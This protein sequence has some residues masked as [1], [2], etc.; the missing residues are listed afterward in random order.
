MPVAARVNHEDDETDIGV[1]ENLLEE[2]LDSTIHFD[3]CPDGHTLTPPGPADPYTERRLRVVAAD[4]R[5]TVTSRGSDLTGDP[6]KTLTARLKSLRDHGLRLLEAPTLWHDRESVPDEQVLLNPDHPD[7]DVPGDNVLDDSDIEEDDA[8]AHCVVF[9]G[10]L[11]LLAADDRR[12]GEEPGYDR[13]DDPADH[14]YRRSGFTRR[15]EPRP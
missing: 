8:L 14:T 11:D 5:V 2:A 10:G 7:H 1:F 15:D 13:E 4:A 12:G 6:T 3:G 9:L